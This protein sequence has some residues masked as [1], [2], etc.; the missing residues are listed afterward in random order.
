MQKDHQ[1]DK[2]AGG[3]KG[4]LGE[5]LQDTGELMRR[6]ASFADADIEERRDR[7]KREWEAARA[8]SAD[9]RES[10]VDCVD[11]FVRAAD[12]CA[13]RHA[14]ESIVAA[15]AVGVVVGLCAMRHGRRR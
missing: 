3:D 7:L 15:A 8:Q 10:A 2:P 5:T 11:R 14:W 6:G 12:R 9:W 4:S 1:D 13:H